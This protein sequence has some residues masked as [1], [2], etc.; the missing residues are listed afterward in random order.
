MHVNARRLPGGLDAK[1]LAA[2]LISG[3]RKVRFGSKAD[4]PGSVYLDN[5]GKFSL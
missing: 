2:K 3:C 4:A 1:R 5:G